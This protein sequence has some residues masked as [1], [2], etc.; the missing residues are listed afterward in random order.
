MPTN[1]PRLKWIAL[2]YNLPIHPSKNRVYV[3]RKLRD[4]GAVGVN[5]GVS[6]LPK[7]SKKTADLVLLC[8]RIRESGGEASIIEMNFVNQRDEQA[9]VKRFREQSGQEY[10]ELLQESG[11]LCARLAARTSHLD[12][13]TSDEIKKMVKRY[14]R[15]RGRSYFGADGETEL[16]KRIDSIFDRCVA[17]ASEFAAQLRKLVEKAKF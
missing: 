16:E 17:D 13:A 11:S 14:S 5:H 1:A 10:A 15:V 7:S 12:E 4:I 2:T 9:M 6:V 8:E 3:W